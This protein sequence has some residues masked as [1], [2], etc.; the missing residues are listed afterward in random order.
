MDEL[1]SK[2]SLML[3]ARGIPTR[4]CPTCASELFTIQATFDENYEVALYLLN[5]ECAMCHTKLTAPTP[6]DLV[7][8]H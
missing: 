8:G 7:D 3:D 5:A 4:E 6:L 1:Y 2:E